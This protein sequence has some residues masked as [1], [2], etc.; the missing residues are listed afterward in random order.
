MLSRI[1]RIRVQNHQRFQLV[2][3][4]IKSLL[5]HYVFE[6]LS[7]LKRIIS[8]KIPNSKIYI[9]HIANKKGIEIGG[10]TP[11][12]RHSLPL[13][14]E[15][16][17]LDG[18]NFSNSTIWKGDNKGLTFNYFKNK[19]GNQI[20]AEA[21]DLTEIE[22]DRYDFCLSSNCLEHVANPLKALNEWNRILKTNGV[23]VLI[24]PNKIN[25]FDHNRPTTSFEH[26]LE[27]YNNNTNEYD[28][29][30]LNEVL[31]LHDLSMDL[32]AGNFEN[33]K[34]R[35]LDNYDNRGLHHHVFDLD[36][37]EKM[38]K[39][40]GFNCVQKNQT[41]MDFFILATKNN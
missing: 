23:L 17:S 10:P 1:K 33:F 7:T 38:I 32:P 35:C 21:T 40:A 16:K 24:L 29:A 8:K 12:F 13:Y 5:P 28:L 3:N 11:L 25:N 36:L 27:D 14:K 39:F 34:Q 41:T 9:N 30:C 6:A 19:M 4:K 31:E 20:F 37:M 26:L 2:K 18:V 15:I 22:N